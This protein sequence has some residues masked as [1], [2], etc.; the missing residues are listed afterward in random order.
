[1][2]DHKKEG[3]SHQDQ[4]FAG[5]RFLLLQ[6]SVALSSIIMDMYFLVTF[7]KKNI[8]SLLALFFYTTVMLAHLFSKQ[9]CLT[10]GFN[11]PIDVQISSVLKKKKSSALALLI[12]FLNSG[13]ASS[14]L[15]DP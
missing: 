6:K 13:S 10:C 8:I 15:L 5:S 2:Q 11:R 14:N 7:Y 3:L 12:A 4:T 9:Q 1:V